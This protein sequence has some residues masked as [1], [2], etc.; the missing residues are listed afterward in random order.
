[1]ETRPDHALIQAVLEGDLRAYEQL[2]LRHQ[3][4]V[5]HFVWRIVPQEQDREEVCQDVFLKVYLNLPKFRFESKFTTWLL[6]IAYRV[7]VSALRRNKDAAHIEMSPEPAGESLDED[8]MGAQIGQLVAQ[9]IDKLSLDERSIVTLFHLK[10][11]SVEEIAAIVGKPAGTV[12]SL[13]FR[14]RRKMK[15][16]LKRRLD[17]E[18]LREVAL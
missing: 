4:M 8:A 18:P 1:M 15:D 2:V 13:L 5:A 7:A 6:S 16:H 12:K 10:E 14:A 11:C 17:R 3:D 9:E